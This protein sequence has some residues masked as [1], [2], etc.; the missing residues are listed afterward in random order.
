MTTTLAAL[1]LDVRQLTYE[2]VSKTRFKDSEL[3]YEGRCKIASHVGI[4]QPHRKRRPFP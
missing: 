2:S 3:G 4:R 1:L